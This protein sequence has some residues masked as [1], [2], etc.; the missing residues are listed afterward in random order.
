MLQL[1][2]CRALPLTSV[3]S[4]VLV[5]AVAAVALILFMIERAEATG[6]DHR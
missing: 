2:D 6:V 1:A 4:V 3:T 5:V